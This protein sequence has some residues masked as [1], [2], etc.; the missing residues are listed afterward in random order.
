[1]KMLKKT[2]KWLFLSLIGLLLIAV[3][4]VVLFMKLSPQIGGTVSDEQKKQFEQLDHYEK[5]KF[6]NAEPVV[7][8]FSFS[9]LKELAFEWFG[10]IPNATPRKKIEVRPF[11]VNEIGQN[12]DGGAR[13]T[14]LGHSSFLIEMDDKVLLID[15]VFSEHAAP[16]PWL[17][18]KRFTN[19]M[20]F[21][22]SDLKKVDAVLISHDHYDHLDYK[23][24]LALKDKVERAYVPL[25]V[26]VHFK[27]WGFA[28]EK[29]KEMDWWEETQYGGLKIAFAPSRHGSGRGFSQDATLWGS[30]ALFGEGQ[31]IYFSGDGGYGV[32]FKAIGEKYG[33]FDFGMI[34]CGQYDKKWATYHLSPEESV[35]AGLDAGAEVFM[36]IHWGA[37]KLASHSWTDPV[38]RFTKK[39]KEVNARITTPAIG[40]SVFIPSDEFPT[41]A[42][43]K[44]FD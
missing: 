26:G 13:A 3:L 23:T 34:E 22:L 32:H 14:W 21:Q 11:N 31:K 27:A 25:G 2:L 8:D 43:W 38:E 15:P 12:L 6:L 18:V 33:P 4:T 41:E 19:G 9:N 37:F 35:Q 24:M 10:N 17:G 29:I 5:G 36:P 40:Q 42:W 39:A 7:L 1:M 16:H 30:W 44:L 20:P 28:P